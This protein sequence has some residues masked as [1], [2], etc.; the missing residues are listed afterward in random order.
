MVWWCGFL[1]SSEVVNVQEMNF[2]EETNLDDLMGL[3]EC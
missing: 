3:R 2:E 1:G